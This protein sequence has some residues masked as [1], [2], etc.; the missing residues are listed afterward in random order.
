[1]EF[2]SLPLETQAV[3]DRGDDDELLEHAQRLIDDRHLEEARV[4]LNFAIDRGVE[5]DD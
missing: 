3:V 5:T 2:D 1:M 4:C